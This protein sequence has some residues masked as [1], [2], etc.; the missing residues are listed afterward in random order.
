MSHYTLRTA[1][2]ADAAELQQLIFGILADYS[3]ATDPAGTDADLQDVERYY[4]QRGGCFHVLTDAAGHIIGSVAL[5]PDAQGHAELRKMYLAPTHRGQGLGRRLLEHALAEARSRGI[6]RLWLE[7]ASVLKEALQLYERY[8]FTPFTSSSSQ[9]HSSR[10]DALYELTLSDTMSPMISTTEIL[11]QYYALF[12][13]GD[14][15]AFLALLSEDVVHDINQGETQVGKE[16][17]RS[18]LQRMDRSYA[19]QVEELV[20]MADSS[21]SRGAAEFYIRGTYLSTD[22]G[23]PPATGQTY[24]LRVGAFFELKAGLVSRVT[25]YYNLQDWLQQVGAA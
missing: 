10:C 24:R 6:T 25:N 1:T 19:E 17:F 14:R 11:Q 5:L 13:S 8:G 9:P 4:F 7:T 22:E 16:A 20:V 15:E 3:L 18:F 12:N 23:L 21:G 2:T